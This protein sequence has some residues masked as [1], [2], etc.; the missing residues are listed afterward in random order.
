MLT[1]SPNRT[2]KKG[3]EE[4]FLLKGCSY[5]DLDAIY[6]QCHTIPQAG[7]KHPPCSTSHTLSEAA[8]LCTDLSCSELESQPRTA[9]QAGP[10]QKP[11]GAF[12]AQPLR[13]TPSLPPP[14]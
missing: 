11:S 8:Q 9:A 10:L 2:L 12:L 1:S 7:A 13:L 14:P 6:L 5:G 4:G 3:R